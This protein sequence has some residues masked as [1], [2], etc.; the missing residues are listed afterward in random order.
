MV[1]LANVDDGKDGDDGDGVEKKLSTDFVAGGCGGPE[2]NRYDDGGGD[3]SNEYVPN[4]E[5]LFVV[6]VRTVGCVLQ[7]QFRRAPV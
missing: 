6:F 1:G 4:E 3:S 7:Q 5:F 2:K